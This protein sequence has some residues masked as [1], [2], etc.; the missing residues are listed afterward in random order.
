MNYEWVSI[1]IFLI[2]IILFIWLM[3][4]LLI[5]ANKRTL[6]RIAKK[7]PEFSDEKLLKR[8]KN[9]EKSRKNKFL[10]VYLSGIFYKSALK[11]NEESLQMYQSEIERRGLM[12]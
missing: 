9:L 4:K 11:M 12:P 5:K 7:L 8:Y 2:V 3:N 10:S 1:I 6:N